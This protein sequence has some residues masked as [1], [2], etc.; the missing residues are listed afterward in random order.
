MHHKRYWTGFSPFGD[1][2]IHIKD[3]KI[4]CEIC[5]ELWAAEQT[6]VYQVL[7]GVEVLTNSTVVA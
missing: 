3:T 7:A 5:E 1:A 4:G 2:I 6:H